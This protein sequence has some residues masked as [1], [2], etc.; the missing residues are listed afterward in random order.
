MLNYCRP[1]LSRMYRLKL[2]V[3][4]Y[5]C[6]KEIIVDMLSVERNNILVRSYLIG[7][8]SERVLP[9]RV[10]EVSHYYLLQGFVC[11]V[12]KVFCSGF[13][14]AFSY[15]VGLTFIYS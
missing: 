11:H 8:P 15:R 10:L 14:L 6:S 4:I 1:S 2:F 13:H 5:H 3:R 7:G 9:N 12:K